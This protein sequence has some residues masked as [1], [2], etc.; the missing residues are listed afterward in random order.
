MISKIP[1]TILCFIPVLD[2]EFNIFSSSF[3]SKVGI[4]IIISSI[5]IFSDLYSFAIF[6]ISFIF[7]FT[8]IEQI[9]FLFSSSSIKHRIL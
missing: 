2:I 3:C 7:P 6:S 8:F 5:F 1:G 9:S 4:A